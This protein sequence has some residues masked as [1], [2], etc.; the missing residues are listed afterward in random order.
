MHGKLIKS[1]RKFKKNKLYVFDKEL[2]LRNTSHYNT[3]DSIGPGT[4]PNAADDAIIEVIDSTH[5][6]CKFGPTNFGVNSKWCKELTKEDAKMKKNFYGNKRYRFRKKILISRLG[7]GNEAPW[8]DLADGQEVIIVDKYNGYVDAGQIK[9]TIRP[10]W[11]EEIQD[12]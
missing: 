5:G 9:L 1:L 2:F 11:C 8:Q 3:R 7:G 10:E 6:N 12:E 4:W